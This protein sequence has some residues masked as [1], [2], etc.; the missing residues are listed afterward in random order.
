MPPLPQRQFYALVYRFRLLEQGSDLDRMRKRKWAKARIAHKLIQEDRIQALTPNEAGELYRSLPISQG[1]RS[2]FLDNPIEELRESLWF[3]LYEELS[4][5]MRVWEFL[6]DMG[7]YRLKGGD[8]SL[9]AALFFTREPSLYGLVNTNVE[10][11]LRRLGMAPKYDSNESH[12]GRFQKVQ[13][14]VWQVQGMARFEDFSVT[15][16]FLEALAKGM[17]DDA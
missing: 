16:D 11:G 10:K 7:G 5:E 9:A 1:K 4:Y 17:L 3:L 13:E 6:D 12:A 2:D 15:D 8:R 14:A